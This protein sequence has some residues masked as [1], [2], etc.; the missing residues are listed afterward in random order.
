MTT[1]DSFNRSDALRA[2]HSQYEVLKA[3][4]GDSATTDALLSHRDGFGLEDV[5]RKLRQRPSMFGKPVHR[6]ILDNVI[7]MVEATHLAQLVLDQIAARDVARIQNFGREF[8][9][10]EQ[11][12][13][14][15]FVDGARETAPL[16]R[17]E[18]GQPDDRRRLLARPRNR[19]RDRSM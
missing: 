9:I 16:M 6:R 10:D 7:A 12:G 4:V 2:F 13:V 17:C 8:E 14:I 19:G 18:P 15:R 1:A 3:A 11:A 5:Q